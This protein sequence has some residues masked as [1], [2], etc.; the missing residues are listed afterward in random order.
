MGK[1]V[2][3]TGAN[4]GFGLL[5][6]KSLAANGHQVVGTMRNPEGRP[7]GKAAIE[8]AGASVVDLDVTSEESVNQGV[9]S[10]IDILGGLDVVVNNAGVGV[11]GM[12]E[13]FTTDDMHKLFNVNLYGVHRVNRAAIPHMRQQGS[14]LLVHVS[15]F[16]LLY[17]SPSPRDA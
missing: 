11:L 9:Q 10:A 12:Q 13:H 8:E 1:K 14:G 15:S 7:E 16:C 2:L 5:T 4:S 6:V 17:T 3:V